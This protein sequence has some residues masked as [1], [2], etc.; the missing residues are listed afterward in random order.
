MNVKKC[1]SQDQV[2]KEAWAI[3][4]KVYASCKLKNVMVNIGISGG[5]MPSMLANNL[6]NHEIDWKTVHFFFCDERYVPLD[7]PDSTYNAYKSSLFQKISIPDSNVHL[8]RPELPLND[9]ASDYQRDIINHFNSS[10][11]PRFDLLFL[12]IGPDGHTCSLFPN[13]KLLFE[14]NLLIAPI[15]DSPKPPPERVTMTLPVICNSRNIV[16]IVTGEGKADILKKLLKDNLT[17]VEYPCNLIQPINGELVWLVD[18][19]AGKKL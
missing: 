2:Y 11:L 18:E 7:H 8:I 19:S 17:G 4:I 9:A 3:F 6:P 15:Q 14:E 16:F 1:D 12:G 5:S 13:H 10:S